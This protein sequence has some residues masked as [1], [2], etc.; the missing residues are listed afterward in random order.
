MLE[1]GGRL[2]NGRPYSQL[3]QQ[4]HEHDGSDV[5]DTFGGVLENGNKLFLLSRVLIGAILPR[6]RKAFI[7]FRNQLWLPLFDM[8]VLKFRRASGGNYLF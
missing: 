6:C 7:R 2:I 4:F 1:R 5:V 3:T 8:L